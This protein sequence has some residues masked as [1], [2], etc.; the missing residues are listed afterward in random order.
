MSIRQLPSE[1][2]L[3]ADNVVNHHHPEN[4]YFGR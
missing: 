1:A 2:F 3:C 4:L